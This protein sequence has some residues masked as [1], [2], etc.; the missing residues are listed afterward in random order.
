MRFKEALQYILKEEGGYVNHPKDPGGM[1]NLGV[2]RRALEDFKGGHVSDDEMRT[3]TSESVAPFYEYM[4]WDKCR[5]GE[6]PSRVA[7]IVFD[8]AVNQGVPTA[9][10]ILQEAVGAKVDGV[11]GPKTMAMVKVCASRET[12]YMVAILRAK[13][14]LGTRN[15]ETFGKGW[16]NRLYSILTSAL[17]LAVLGD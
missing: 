16:G 11:L 6:L 1:T 5:C 4:Y 13:R 10:R 15:V 14:Y 12:V 2:T 17:L 3:L 9:C 7:L 8:C